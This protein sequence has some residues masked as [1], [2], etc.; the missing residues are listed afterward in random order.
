MFRKTVI[1]RK[2]G[3]WGQNSSFGAHSQSSCATEQSDPTTPIKVSCVLGSTISATVVIGSGNSPSHVGS[4]D[5][6]RLASAVYATDPTWSRMG[7]CSVHAIWYH[8][9][10]GTNRCYSEASC[11]ASPCRTQQHHL[12][13]DRL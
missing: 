11:A 8:M 3:R 2:S 4:G 13:F 9:I 6:S 10:C 12:R 5:F 1:S 7:S